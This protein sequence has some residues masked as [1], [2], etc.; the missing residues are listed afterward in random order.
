MIRFP[1]RKNINSNKFVV[2]HTVRPESGCTISCS[3][4]LYKMGQ[5][6][7]GHRVQGCYSDFLEGFICPDRYFDQLIVRKT[8]VQSGLDQ[9]ILRKTTVQSK[10]GMRAPR[11]IKEY[12]E[13]GKQLTLDFI[14][15]CNFTNFILEDTISRLP[16]RE[17]N[18]DKQLVTL[19]TVLLR[20]ARTKKILVARRQWTSKL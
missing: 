19:Q 8:T 15:K 5:L 1:V 6:L 17:N 9:V 11:K 4:L 7:T 14:F 12:L 3:N 10:R 2:P 16:L 13:A 18:N 20:N